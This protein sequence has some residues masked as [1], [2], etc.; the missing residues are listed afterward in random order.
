MKLKKESWSFVAAVFDRE[1]KKISLYV[2]GELAAQRDRAD[3]AIGAVSAYPLEIGHYCASKTQQFKGRLDE[4][5]LYSRALS[6]QEIAAEFK[7]QGLA[8][9]AT[10]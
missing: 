7:E 6:P 1:K 5:R 8:V 10:R 2:N 3:G 9:K 4:I